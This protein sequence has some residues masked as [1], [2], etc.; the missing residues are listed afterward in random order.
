ME[1]SF[2]LLLMKNTKII[3]LT[4]PLTSKYRFFKKE[5][6]LLFSSILVFLFFLRYNDFSFELT[7]FWLIYFSVLFFYHFV[8]INPKFRFLPRFILSD[9]AIKLKRTALTSS[10]VYILANLKR[11]PFSSFEFVLKCINEEEKKR[12]RYRWNR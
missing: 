1:K 3:L 12:I 2:V 9:N 6:Y 4:P 11:V 8:L 7:I 10:Q 5:K